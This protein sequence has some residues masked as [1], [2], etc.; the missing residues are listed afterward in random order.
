MQHK[1]NVNHKKTLNKSFIF[2]DLII[3]NKPQ[4]TFMKLKMKIL[5]VTV[6]KKKNKP[7]CGENRI[8]SC[9]F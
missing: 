2:V 3:R 5:L 4:Y 9:S 7:S 1:V 8:L 6:K